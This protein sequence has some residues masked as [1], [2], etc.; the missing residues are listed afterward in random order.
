[1]SDLV[2]KYLDFYFN[3][4]R[5]I[6]DI[7]IIIIS[8]S[9]SLYVTS[10][11]FIIFDTDIFIDMMF[12]IILFSI[13]IFNFYNLYNDQTR[14]PLWDILYSFIPGIFIIIIFSFILTYYYPSLN[15][16]KRSF[17][18]LY[19]ILVILIIIWRYILIKVQKRFD[20]VKETVIIGS[21]QLTTKLI[22]NIKKHT[23]HGYKIIEVIDK[24]IFKELNM[25]ELKNK[26]EDINPDIL[27]LTSDISIKD[28]E[29]LFHISLEKE[30]EIS[31]IPE[32]Y[33]IMISGVELKQ[34]GEFP[35][36]NVRSLKKRN[37]SIIK[38]VLDILYSF[39]ALIIL[40][41]FIILISI[42]IKLTSEGPVLYKQKRVSQHGDEFKVYK[43]RTMIENAEE[44]TG[45]VLSGNNDQRITKVGKILRKTRM[46][47]IPQLINVLKGDMSLI[48]PRPE[49]P[50]FVEKF[51]KEISYYKF[52]HYI[53][54]GLT[55]LAQ[56][57]GFYST[58]AEE[59]LR[60]DLIYANNNNILFDIKIILNTLKVILIGEK[61]E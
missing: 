29:E 3:I 15:F 35:I 36:Y 53:K 9:F 57:H 32:F 10:G 37:K 28:K 5:I 41:P 51:N 45:P 26:L 52:R 50:H 20:S 46:D 47:E 33:E 14:K 61:A 19:L 56:I 12:P 8:F 23:N 2:K 27:F 4:I 7:F 22:K 34:I 1:V 54:S 43:F 42:A 49:R 60:M 39:L 48:G 25:T 16:P 55:G 24:N 59:K 18:Y 13:L 30:W 21:E 31:I 40:L 6:G 58:D 11:K 17:I 38:R 44:K